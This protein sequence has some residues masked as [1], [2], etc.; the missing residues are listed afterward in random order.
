MTIARLCADL[1]STGFIQWKC[2]IKLRVLTIAH[3]CPGC[4]CSPA[5]RLVDCNPT[6]CTAIYAPVC[7]SDGKTYSSE[8]MLQGANRE[9]HCRYINLPVVCLRWLS[10]VIKHSTSTEVVCEFNPPPTQLKLICGIMYWFFPGKT[11][12]SVNTSRF[13]GFW[14]VRPWKQ[15][16]RQYK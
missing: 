16:W 13:W 12:Y 10:P 14:P 6:M 5:R 11:K 2:F 4:M 1:N 15:C 7:G 9:N 3:L 8:C